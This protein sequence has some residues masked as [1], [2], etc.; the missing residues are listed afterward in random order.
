MKNYFYVEGQKYTN[1]E[2]LNEFIKEKYFVILPDHRYTL[3]LCGIVNYD[4]TFYFFFP[5]GYNIEMYSNED[6][7]ENA[8]LLFKSI[9]KYKDS[10]KLDELESN[11][12]GN[13][14]FNI[15]YI[16]LV[17]WIIKDYFAHGLYI[18]SKKKYEVN[19]K[20]FIDWNRSINK[21]VPI[22]SD[23]KIQYV[24]LITRKTSY[25]TDNQISQ[26]HE[27]ILLECLDN[28]GWLF[29]FKSIKKRGIINVDLKQQILILKKKLRETFS[30]R[31]IKLLQYLI[32]YLDSKQDD[33]KEYVIVTPYFNNIWEK[34]LQKILSTNKA[35]LKNVPKPYWKIPTI[36]HFLY[37]KQIPDI[38][39]EYGQELIIIDAKY[40]SIETNQVE[41]FPGWESIVKQMYYSLSLK[42]NSYSNIKNIFLLPQS[43]SSNTYQYIGYTGV[44]GKEDIFGYVKAFSIDIVTVLQAYSKVNESSFLDILIQQYDKEKI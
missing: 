10:V 11:W 34:M 24:N 40:Y 2:I 21:S 38:L 42:N 35:L 41:K 36:P 9:F 43:L 44:E 6:N 30:S 32:S 14:N 27:S 31:E 13:T 3:K 17:T 29:N 22:I 16:N 28:F 5:K 33:N 37:T 25:N 7:I 18:D 20:G 12:I 8:K 4:K 19:G 23:N 26:I 39:I 15:Q 1:K